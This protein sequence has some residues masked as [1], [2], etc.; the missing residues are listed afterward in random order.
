MSQFATSYPSNP[1]ICL[2]CRRP[3]EVVDRYDDDGNFLG[4]SYVHATGAGCTGSIPVFGEEGAESS[5]QVSVCDFCHGPEVAWDYPADDFPTPGDEELLMTGVWKA[6][7]PCH[8]D[9]EAGD[10]HRIIER[11]SVVNGMVVDGPTRAHV[12]GIYSEFT[13]RRR[14][15]ATRI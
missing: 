15:A 5:D 1:A 12:A 6:C 13:L 9:I 11:W 8:D 3:Y 7:H 4:A 14:G 10:W 2:K